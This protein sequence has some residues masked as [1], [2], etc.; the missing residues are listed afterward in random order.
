MTQERKN[1][2]YDQMLAWICERIPGDEELF[3]ILHEQFGM[4]QDELHEHCIDSLDSFFTVDTP[5]KL[6]KKKVLEN[7]E[8]YKA[9]WLR[10][11]P[12]DLIEQCDQVEGI[13]RMMQE[14][15]SSSVSDEDAE[16]LLRFKN[17]LEVVSDEWIGRNGMDFLVIDDEMRHLLWSLKDRGVAEQSYEMEPEFSDEDEAPALSM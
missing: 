1:L 8:E 3:R 12:V 2:L 15:T 9:K 4:T 6:L 17:P 7:Y 5:S 16:Y 14:L 10:M 11:K 13:T